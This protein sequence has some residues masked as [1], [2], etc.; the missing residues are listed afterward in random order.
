MEPFAYQLRDIHG[1]DPVSWWPPAP[2]WWLLALG[3]ILC[4]WLLWR[5]L[6]LLR[7]PAGSQGLRRPDRQGLAC[8][9][10]GQRSPKL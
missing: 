4:L 9:A 10:A 1:P 8:L 6:P 2:G 5:L 3:T 7:I